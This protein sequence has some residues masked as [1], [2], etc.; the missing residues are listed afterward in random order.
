MALSYLRSELL[1]FTRHS[2]VR[3]GLVD[4]ILITKVLG[5]FTELL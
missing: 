5:P 4:K 3:E 1:F 2:P